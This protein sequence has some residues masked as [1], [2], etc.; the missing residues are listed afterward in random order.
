M[1]LAST[2]LG[3]VYSINLAQA[4]SQTKDCV[5]QLYPEPLSKPSLHHLAQPILTTHEVLLDSCHHL[6]IVYTS[7][8][9]TITLSN[10]IKEHPMVLIPE[11]LGSICHSVWNANLRTVVVSTNLGNHLYVDL[12]P[13]FN[14]SPKSNYELSFQLIGSMQTSKED[15]D[16][17]EQQYSSCFLNK[18]LLLSRPDSILWHV[19]PPSTVIS[20][21][22]AFK[23]RK[24]PMKLNKLYSVSLL[25]VSL[26]SGP[27]PHVL[28]LS[29]G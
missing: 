26:C 13:V 10:Q 9:K 6:I 27:E 5:T 20:T 18:Q 16:P 22:S 3:F 23:S 1:L 12:K 25:V 17:L 4:L 28:L 14:D 15:C 11:R 24:K 7:I 29:L 21:S 8:V 2:S 19:N